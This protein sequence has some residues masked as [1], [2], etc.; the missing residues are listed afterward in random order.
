MFLFQLVGSSIN[1][2]VCIRS[3]SSHAFRLLQRHIHCLENS[4]K[5]RFN[6]NCLEGFFFLFHC[7][8]RGCLR[9]YTNTVSFKALKIAVR[10][11]GGRSSWGNYTTLVLSACVCRTI[12][13]ADTGLSFAWIQEVAKFLLVTRLLQWREPSL[14]TLVLHL[15][16]VPAC[17]CTVDLRDTCWA[18]VI[19]LPCILFS[20]FVVSILVQDFDACRGAATI[21]LLMCSFILLLLELM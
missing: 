5:C 19:F 4:V 16:C 10:D 1:K 18:I 3:L 7:C 11:R 13:S 9:K 14:H 17:C 20:N 15:N 21:I 2:R 6:V 12:Y 8:R